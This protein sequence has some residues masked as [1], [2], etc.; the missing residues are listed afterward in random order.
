MRTIRNCAPRLIQSGTT[1]DG[2][3]YRVYLDDLT[4]TMLGAMDFE[5]M[6]RAQEERDRSR[7]SSWQEPT[8]RGGFHKR[9][10]T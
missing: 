6:R 3:P 5:A 10:E 4:G 9:R 8:K 7:F 2:I 1:R